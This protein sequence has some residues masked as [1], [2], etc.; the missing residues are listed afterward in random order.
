MSGYPGQITVLA[1]HARDTL[2][3]LPDNSVD[4][5]VTSP[6]YWGLRDYGHSGAIGLE[7]TLA[8]FLA[9]LVLVFEQVRRVLKPGGTCWVNMGDSYFSGARSSGL[10]RAHGVTRQASPDDGARRPTTA[11]GLRIKAKDLC[12][13][14]WRLALALQDAGWYLRRDIIWQKPNAAPES[15][16]DRPTSAHD[17]IFLLTKSAKYWYDNQAFREPVTGNAHMRIAKVGR[18]AYGAGAHNAIAKQTPSEHQKLSRKTGQHAGNVRDNTSYAAAVTALVESRNARSVWT[19]PSEAYQGAHFAT[20]PRELPRR[21]ILLGCP[22]GGLVLDPFMGSGTT[23]QVAIE[24]G[25]RFVGCEINPDYID[26]A[27]QRLASVTPGLPFDVRT[28][29]AAA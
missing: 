26:L 20:F 28:D 27:R 5:C 25:R 13:Q 17:Y 9:N 16:R 15:A 21:C 11:P 2:S 1:G 24:L 7:H 14:P 3:T 12:G 8:G 6:P 18:N 22:P 10:P 29:L 19:F 23:G 4:C